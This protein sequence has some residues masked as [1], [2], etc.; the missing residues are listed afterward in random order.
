M[1]S[2]STQSGEVISL[3]TKIGMSVLAVTIGLAGCSNA[4]SKIYD[5]FKCG[6]VARMLGRNADAE[7]ASKKAEPYFKEIKQRPSYYALQLSEK[8]TDDLELHRY[9]GMGAMKVIS[10]TYKSSTCQKLYR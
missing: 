7:A 3:T 8:F 4:D 6:K 9:S 5:A 2:Y 10:D 1:K